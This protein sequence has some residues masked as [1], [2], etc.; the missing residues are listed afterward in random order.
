MGKSPRNL[1]NT[2]VIINHGEKRIWTKWREVDT[3]AIG[4]K[5][6]NGRDHALE[7]LLRTMDAGSS[8]R[9]RRPDRDERLD[10]SKSTRR[11][12]RRDSRERDTAR[13]RIRD[14]PPDDYRR[15]SR[16]DS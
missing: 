2:D 14:D 7:R 1:I 10:D 6:G 9:R 13:Q 5:G 15:R 12:P 3:L 11:S 4:M 8:S 16:R